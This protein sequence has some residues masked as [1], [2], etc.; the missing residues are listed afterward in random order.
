M[1]TK[2]KQKP[3]TAPL[4]LHPKVKHWKKLR[5]YTEKCILA[6]I[7][8]SLEEGDT[9]E[10]FYFRMVASGMDSKESVN[11]AVQATALAM[12]FEPHYAND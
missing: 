12:L 9:P 11:T 5:R 1:K 7:G 8:Q 2:P 6:V 4:K 3:T 10:T